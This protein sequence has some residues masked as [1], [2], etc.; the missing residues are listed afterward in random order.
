M[1]SCPYGRTTR[2]GG[3]EVQLS[4]DD[5]W[6]APG[7]GRVSTS[8]DSDSV[9]LCKIGTYHDRLRLYDNINDNKCKS[10]DPDR[11]TLPSTVSTWESSV[12][13][14]GGIRITTTQPG[15]RSFAECDQCSAG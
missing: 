15:A 8:S 13:L 9:E 12:E 4:V 7:F 14:K 10:C 5:C 6:I 2:P 3:P 1:H 11:I